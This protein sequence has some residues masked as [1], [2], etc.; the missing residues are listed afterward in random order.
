[1]LEQQTGLCRQADKQA[2]NLCI[3]EMQQIGYRKGKRI[4]AASK[5]D[6]L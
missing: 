3:A 5:A 1:L 4:Q 6:S 2:G